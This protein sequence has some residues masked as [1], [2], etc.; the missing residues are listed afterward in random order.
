MPRLYRKFK[1]S[2]TPSRKSRCMWW[3]LLVCCSQCP[4]ASPVPPPAI[5]MRNGW[6]AGAAGKFP[7]LRWCAIA[8]GVI[9]TSSAV[10][11]AMSTVSRPPP[12]TAGSRGGYGVSVYI[13]SVCAM[14]RQM[15][16]AS[17]T[18]LGSAAGFTLNI[19]SYQ[20]KLHKHS[21]VLGENVAK[22]WLVL[23]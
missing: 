13:A 5:R 15:L 2:E 14:S 3:G 16:R 19:R 12:D 8:A 20:P 21:P 1:L 23:M 18:Q 10:M 11:P 22:K 6:P 9:F 7:P 4:V 17:L